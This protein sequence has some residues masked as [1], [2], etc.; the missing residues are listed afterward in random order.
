M[1]GVIKHIVQEQGDDVVKA[2]LSHPTEDNFFI[3]RI[4]GILYAAYIAFL[5]SHTR[6]KERISFILTRLN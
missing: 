4:L 3:S 1:D 2:S 5:V 6:A